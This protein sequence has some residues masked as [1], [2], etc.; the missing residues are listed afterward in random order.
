MI[1]Y[2]TCRGDLI[3]AFFRGKRKIETTKIRFWGWYSPGAIKSSQFLA[4]F[5]D[6]R[7]G[8]LKKK[9]T[10][11]MFLWFP[12]EIWG[13][14]KCVRERSRRFCYQCSASLGKVIWFCNEHTDGKNVH[15]SSYHSD[16]L[17]RS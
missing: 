5:L 8:P 15:D 9:N 1:F 3:V 6:R 13:H 11:P 2:P 10:S 4:T 17:H 12:Y 16:L 7:G 14:H